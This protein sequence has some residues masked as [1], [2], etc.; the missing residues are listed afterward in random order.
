MIVLLSVLL[1]LFLCFCFTGKVSDSS[2]FT[3]LIYS[4]SNLWVLFNDRIIINAHA[5]LNFSIDPSDTIKTWLT[6][7]EYS[8]V[9]I[10]VSARQ[11]WGD[12][13]KWIVILIIHSF[14]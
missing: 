9:F 13:V 8:E 5:K 10:E 14:K 7:L 6:V 1:F 3:E 2:V 11:V 4:I 12:K